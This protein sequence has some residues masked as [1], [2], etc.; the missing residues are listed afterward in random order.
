MNERGPVMCPECGYLWHLTDNQC[1]FVLSFEKIKATC[2]KCFKHISA[3]PSIAK[4]QGKNSG[5]FHA[6]KV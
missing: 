4:H 5:V 1:R 3:V 2:P 6:T